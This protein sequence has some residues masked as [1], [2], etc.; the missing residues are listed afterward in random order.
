M[1]DADRLQA[2]DAQVSALQWRRRLEQG[3]VM[4]LGE[5]PPDHPVA[6]VLAAYAELEAVD[7][8]ART[9][10]KMP[11]MVGGAWFLL[12]A[13][14]VAINPVIAGV[15]SSLLGVAAFFVVSRLANRKGG[16]RKQQEAAQALGEAVD[17][18]LAHSFVEATDSVVVEHSADLHYLE[19]RIRDARAGL[20]ALRGKRGELSA[21]AGQLK[22]ANDKAGLEGPDSDLEAIG[23]ELLE[24]QG[25]SET[26][27]ALLEELEQ[28]KEGLEARMA[29]RRTL[30]LRHGLGQRV[31]RLTSEDTSAQTA[32]ALE[33]DMLELDARLEAA[34]VALRDDDARV[35]A[36][37]E[38]RALEAGAA[39]RR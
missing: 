24:L 9:S 32:A 1:L 13:A 14:L 28:A 31:D 26:L 3:G 16:S 25:R 39:S 18:M 35:R 8:G 30:A 4:G 37:R 29:A 22:D 7:R 23:R 5:L 38:I 21:L 10:W 6:P 20:R 19:T 17:R 12:S 2:G 33:V 34:D 15:G 36:A 11:L 27:R